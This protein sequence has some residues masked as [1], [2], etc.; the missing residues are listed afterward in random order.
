MEIFSHRPES[1]CG[2]LAVL[3]DDRLLAVGTLEGFL[4]GVII[5]KTIQN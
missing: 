1:G 2:R 3:G 5:L 4:F